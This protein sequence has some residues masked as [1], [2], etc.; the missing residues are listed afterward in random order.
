MDLCAQSRAG[1]TL[2]VRTFLPCFPRRGFTLLE[3]LV[4]IAILAMAAVVLGAAYANTLGAHAAVAQRAA[5]GNGMDYLRE[6]I[7]NEPERTKVEEGGQVALPDGRQLR[8]E[9]TIEEATVP[10]LFKIV[11]R[12]Q[13]TGGATK[14]DEQFEQTSMLLRPTWSDKGKREQ[15]RDDW[16]KLREKEARR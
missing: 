7:F 16:T 6:L 8:W 3:V 4:A 5:K 10:D 2:T 11:I 9:A 15:L 13:I 14:D 1:K 12:G